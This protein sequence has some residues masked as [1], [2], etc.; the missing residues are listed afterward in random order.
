MNKSLHAEAI[1]ALQGSGQVGVRE[2]GP[3]GYALPRYTRKVCT[4]IL[5]DSSRIAAYPP[6]SVQESISI[7]FERFSG[8]HFSE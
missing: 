6:F 7:W 4:G 8:S 2:A 3:R 5:K 1:S